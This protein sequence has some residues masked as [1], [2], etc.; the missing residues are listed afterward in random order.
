MRTIAALI[1]GLCIGIAITLGAQGAT[2]D[3]DRAQDQMNAAARKQDTTAW[4]KFVTDDLLV[5]PTDGRGQNKGQRIETIKK[6]EGIAV[7]GSSDGIEALRKRPE[8]RVRTYGDAA[9]VT[10]INPPPNNNPNPPFPKGVRLV[11]VFVK[12]GSE[13]RMAHAQQTP[14]R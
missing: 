8:Y 6:G 13:W 7:G 11:R 3:L 4:E 14:I 1:L 5:V 2:A 9:I 12:Q 10:W